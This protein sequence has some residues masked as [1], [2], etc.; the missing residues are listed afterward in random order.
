MSDPI[1]SA[2]TAD[3]LQILGMQQVEIV[4]MRDALTKAQARVQELEKEKEDGQ[5]PIN[6]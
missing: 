3:L 4:F 6:D 5:K 1:F 2:Q